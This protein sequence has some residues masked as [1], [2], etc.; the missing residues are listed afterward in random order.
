[1]DIENI[2]GVHTTYHRIFVIEFFLLVQEFLYLIKYAVHLLFLRRLLLLQIR[3]NRGE[4]LYRI[5]YLALSLFAGYGCLQLHIVVSMDTDATP[6]CRGG[7][8]REG[9]GS[10]IAFKHDVTSL[11]Y[12]LR[13]FANHVLYT[14]RARI[15]SYLT[16]AG[17]T[18]DDVAGIPHSIEL[19][20]MAIEDNLSS[21]SHQVAA[22]VY[23]ADDN[24]GSRENQALL[25]AIILKA[26]HLFEK[27][28]LH[29]LNLSL[30]LV[31]LFQVFLYAVLKIAKHGLPIV[32]Y[33][34][35]HNRSK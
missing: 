9:I 20:L 1:M 26:F 31:N 27:V 28:G 13:C 12:N 8:H 6:A 10:I 35:C 34:V 19:H 2:Q 24:L 21:T 30:L 32:E 17:R 7:S 18:T 5:L 29:L 15:D 14:V 33:I 4:S 25:I 23:V 22:L 3:D 11:I 16:D